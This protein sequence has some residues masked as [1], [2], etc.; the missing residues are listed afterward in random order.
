MSQIRSAAVSGLFYPADP[1]AL[2]GDIH[3]L[4]DAVPTD[5]HPA[6]KAII[7]PHAGYAYSGPIAASVYSRLRPTARTI[8]RV[9][10]FGPSHR[11]SFPGLA[12]PSADLFETPLGRIPVDRQAIQRLL[13]LPQVSTIDA[14]HAQEHSLEVHLPFLQCILGSFTLVPVIVG[15][16]GDAEVANAIEEVWEGSETLVVISSDLS[17]Y[18][19]YATARSM[20]RSTAEAVLR[21]DP[22]SLSTGQACGRTP[23]A[24]LLLLARR[25]GLEAELVDLRNSG[26]TAGSRDRVVGYGSFAF[27]LPGASRPSRTPD[28]AEIRRH[29][30]HLLDLARQSIAAALQGRESPLATLPPPLDGPGA[31][32]VTLHRKGTLRGC[33]GSPVAWRSL[34]DDIV[35]NAVKAAFEDP[36]FPALTPAEW[37]DIDLSLSVLSPPVPMIFAD[38]ADLLAQ[39]RPHVDGL[40]IEDGGRRALFLPSVWEQLPSPRDFL[41]QLKRKAGLSAGHWSREFKAKRFDAI[42]ISATDPAKDN[43]KP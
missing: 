25:H 4:L 42:E 28:E 35:D 36:R 1:G 21:L 7:A 26:D 32:F 30:R 19:D 5:W 23:I 2:A 17:H 11:L 18:H 16:A 8:T 31:C 9:V 43:R 41:V 33:I 13:A 27:T 38:E 10:L 6:P 20:D 37:D 24:G 12:V 14:A 3:Q 34:G 15:H 39:L 29:G 22:S 40:V